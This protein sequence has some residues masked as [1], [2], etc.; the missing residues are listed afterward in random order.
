[1]KAQSFNF[2]FGNATRWESAHCATT[3]RPDLFFPTTME[4]VR[5]SEPLI[6]QICQ[7]CPVKQECLQLA[8]DAK[9]FNGYFGGV[10]P[11]ERRKMSAHRSRV[12]RGN[13][14]EVIRLM[15]LGWTFED[16]CDEVGILPASFFKWKNQGT[17]TNKDKDKK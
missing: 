5:D 7:D 3:L 9:D 4:E 17:K 15:D 16:A 6:K 2:A 11:D 12:R 13:S 10:S 14:K 8:L 1:M